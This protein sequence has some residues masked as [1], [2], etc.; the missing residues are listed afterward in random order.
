MNTKP[1][2]AVQEEGHY[3]AVVHTGHK[4]DA[5][6]KQVEHG[7]ILRESEWGKNLITLGGFAA[8]LSGSNPAAT[9]V[10]GSGN[11]A[12]TEADTVL[13]SYL[14]KNTVNQ[15]TLFSRTV[16]GTPDGDGYYV[17]ET[18]YRATF[19]P[20]SLGSG[21][22]NVSEA[23]MAKASQSA[24]NA[25]S[26]LLSRGLLVD[27]F[28]APLTISMNATTEYLDIYWRHRR[29]IPAS[30]VGSMAM[31]IMGVSVVHDWE[32]RPIYINPTTTSGGY[33]IH[34]SWWNGINATVGLSVA[35][36]AG[37]VAYITVGGMPSNVYGQPGVLDGALSS[38]TNTAPTGTFLS[39][40]SSNWTYDAYVPGSKQRV[41]HLNLVPTNANLAAVSVVT[42]H[43]GNQGWQMSFDPPVAKQATP[44]RVWRIDLTIAVS[45]KS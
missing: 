13:A 12:P 4:F 17:I 3:R 14:G 27:S 8:L 1:Q 40:S 35:N 10:V 16:S 32:A 5:E 29:Y 20:G 19:Y 36:V 38:A 37:L 39:Y 21:S 43:L 44:N 22:V 15:L 45:N 18:V 30:V 11:T 26:A 2:I 34:R 28:G 41:C 7:E 31:Q 6:G 9:C 24:T 25:T 33:D 23:G 42:F